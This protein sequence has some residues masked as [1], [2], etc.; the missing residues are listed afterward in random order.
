M[1]DLIL[2]G[3]SAGLFAFLICF[4]ISF[5]ALGFTAGVVHLIASVYRYLLEL[6]T[7]HYREQAV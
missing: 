5:I 4:I 7:P 3:L 6:K 2:A 1:I